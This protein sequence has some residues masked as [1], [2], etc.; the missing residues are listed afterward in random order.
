MKLIV[1]LGLSLT[2]ASALFPLHSEQVNRYS[3]YN[4]V[5]DTI[6]ISEMGLT[7][8]TRINAVPFIQKAIEACRG[9]RNAVISF[10]KGRYDFWPHRCI[11]KVY[12]E[13]NTTVNNPRRCAILLEGLSGITLDCGGSDFIFHDRMQP[14]TVDK[15]Q[16]ICIK[17]VSIDWEIPLT[18][19]AEVLEVNANFMVIRV[20]PVE[21]PYIIVKD[22]LVF[23]GEGWSS[24]WWGTMEFDRESRTVAYKTGDW[25]CL[26][27]G[28]NAYKAEELS[29]GLIRLNYA[30]KRLPVKGNYLILRHSERDHSGIFITDSRNVVLEDINMYHNAGL[31]VLSQFAENLAFR[32]I[33]SIPN[34]AKNRILAGHDDGLHFSNCAGQITIEDC[35]FHALMDDPIN[36]HGTCVRI[37]EKTDAHTVICKFM[38]DQSIGMTWA[39]PGEKIGFIEN[40]SMITTSIGVVERFDSLQ[41]DLFSLRFKEPVPAGIEPGFALE[42]LSWTP[43]VLITGSRFESCRARGILMSTPGKVI[44][45][46]NIFESSGS[47]I[48][49]AGDANNWYE[50]GG[51]KDVMI[52]NN[53]FTDRCLTSMYQFCEAVISIYP[54]IP[55]PDPS[56]PGYHRNIRIE[57]NR[58]DLF[59]YPVLYAKSVDNLTFTG[60][61][62]TFS[63]RYQPWHPRKYSVS[64]EFCK[65]VIIKDNVIDP[66]VLGRNIQISGMKKKDVSIG[67]AQFLME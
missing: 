59:D 10:P 58:F 9:G 16:D 38:H 30:F 44:I 15:S 27:A 13:S 28:W 1:L 7:P 51:V 34:P 12:Y 17:K 21:S 47:A 55:G 48:L 26:G 33:N 24:A 50:S 6:R 52:R 22:K 4:G 43:D 32:R 60:N 18:A 49:I 62:L 8:D 41:P 14:F 63:Q 40:S 31:G 37:M 25:G 2:Y 67:K 66:R 36:V 11:E 5:S 61:K 3:G 56:K 29:P 46:N 19:E 20:D 42:N 64:L 53:H 35:R 54:E 65:K 39:R 57:N 23:V 45:E